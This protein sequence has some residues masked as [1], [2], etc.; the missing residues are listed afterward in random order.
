MRAVSK[1]KDRHRLE[2]TAVTTVA[3][4]GDSTNGSKVSRVEEDFSSPPPTVTGKVVVDVTIRNNRRIDVLVEGN[5]TIAWYGWL[6][7]AISSLNSWS[8]YETMV[9]NVIFFF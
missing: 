5:S 2:E 9:L 4:G 1:N 6:E 7:R 8:V 3:G